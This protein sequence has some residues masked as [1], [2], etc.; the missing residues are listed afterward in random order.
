MKNQENNTIVDMGK[1]VI[2]CLFPLEGEGGQRPDEGESKTKN[3]LINYVRNPLTCPVGHSRITTFRDDAFPQGRG[4]TQRGFTAR[5]VTPQSRYA[6]YSGR[7]GFTLIELLVVVLIIGILAAVAVP[8]YQKAVYKARATEGV[9]LSANLQKA[10]D[11]YI[12][13][14]GFPDSYLNLNNK[15]DIQVPTSINFSSDLAFDSD[16]EGGIEVAL[17]IYEMQNGH[18]GDLWLALT[19][20][21]NTDWQKTCYYAEDTPSQSFCQSLETQGWING[22]TW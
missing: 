20:H 16:G 13:E 9:V 1:H 10:V 17:Y 4:G 2:N 6:G 11:L 8:Q 21:E 15:L 3:F 7:T 19:K 22:G 12:L 18:Y 5:S 14:N